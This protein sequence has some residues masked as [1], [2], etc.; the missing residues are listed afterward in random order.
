M[1]MIE[2]ARAFVESLRALA[3][4]TGQAWRRCPQCG[5]TL[6]SK[7]GSYTR[8]PWTLTGRQTVRVQRHKCLR[9]GTTYSETTPGLLRKGW[10]AREVRRCAIDSWQH[11]GLSLRR[12]AEWLRSWLGR[13]ERWLI[14]QVLAPAPAE[15]ARCWL[16]ASTVWRW[17][18]AAGQSAQE[19]VA[20]QLADV[21]TSGQVGLDGLWARLTGRT[22][23]V[24]LAL[25]D[26]VTGV[27]WPPVVVEDESSAAWQQ[28][29]DRAAE[30]GLD[31]DALRGVVS[32]G[33][34]GIGEFLNAHL[35]WVNQQRC[36]FHL[37]RSLSGELRAQVADAARGL[38]GAVAHAVQGKM[39]RDLIGLIRAVYEAASYETALT[40][41]AVLEGHARGQV[42]ARTIRRSL[43]EAFVHQGRVTQ[44][45]ARLVPEYLWRDFR[46]RLSHGRNHRS[47][48]R[49]E[50]AALLFALSHNWEPAQDR[51]ERKRRYRHPGLSPLQVAGVPPNGLSYLDAL[52]V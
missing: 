7:W 48:G 23:R 11:G 19:S 22:K 41:L 12:T 28:L 45:L 9:C 8:H 16:S 5:D 33:A 4:K 47:E 44:G 27:L 21:P 51:R 42:L 29:S 36:V 37:W 3:G 40:A 46:L 10:Y 14:W 52:A 13:H 49:L 18:D 30:A 25:V 20:Q 31:R 1:S 26:C 43:V 39:R 34:A 15:A 6:T 2:R 38:S 24:V 17:L 35:W 50:R 32:D